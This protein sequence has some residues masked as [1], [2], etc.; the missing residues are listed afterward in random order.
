MLY[1]WQVTLFTTTQSIFTSPQVQ[2]ERFEENV[3]GLP[4]VA[5]DGGRCAS[6]GR[7]L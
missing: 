3:C 2:F 5:E 4:G 7:A 1:W 6:P